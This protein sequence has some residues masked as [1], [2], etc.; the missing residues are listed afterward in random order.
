MASRK[1]DES[2]DL[3]MSIFQK[4]LNRHYKELEK[5]LMKSHPHLQL[6]LKRFDFLYSTIVQELLQNLDRFKLPNNQL[7]LELIKG[8][9]E[10]SK[11]T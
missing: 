8:Y 6:Y 9:I 3:R 2:M 11:A 4:T 1:T 10:S 7:N 5:I